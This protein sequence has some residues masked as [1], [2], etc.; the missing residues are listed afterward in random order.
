[1]VEVGDGRD[2]PFKVREAGLAGKA[3]RFGDERDTERDCRC[4]QFG[5]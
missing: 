5:V 3:D 4:L 1:M 2:A